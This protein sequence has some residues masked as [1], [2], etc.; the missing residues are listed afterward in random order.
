M[1]KVEVHL[2]A[3][4][5]ECAGSPEVLVEATD[6][7]GLLRTLSAMF[8]RCFSTLISQEGVV[9]LVNGRNLRPGPRANIRLKSGDEVSIFPPVSGG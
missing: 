3:T 1:P 2:Y 4:V 6:V 9:I 7:D 8:G 5:R